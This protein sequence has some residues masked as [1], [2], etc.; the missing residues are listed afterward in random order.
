MNISNPRK[1]ANYGGH[2]V[3]TGGHV[4][5]QS[6]IGR[7][8]GFSA[9]PTWT[10]S[11]EFMPDTARHTDPNARWFLDSHVNLA[12]AKAMLA[13][14]AHDYAMHQINADAG[15]SP[16]GR[17]EKRQ[18]PRMVALKAIAQATA[19]VATH[20]EALKAREDSLYSVPPL[21]PTDA[22]GAI[23][24]RS[25][26]DHLNSQPAGKRLP[27][28]SGMGER[29]LAAVQRSLTPLEPAEA[30]MATSRYREAVAAREP[31]KAAELKAARENQ[32]WAQGVVADAARYTARSTGLSPG[33]IAEASNVAA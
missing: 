32:D 18:E 5:M 28:I 16:A 3:T 13:L 7:A 33:E 23:Q 12:A 6:V 15:L 22:V 25:V 31:A 20:G 1:I 26:I 27:L 11:T 8:Y 2:L 17:D 10:D 24:D 14:P 29:Q 9:P 21:A 19:D 4:A 30:A